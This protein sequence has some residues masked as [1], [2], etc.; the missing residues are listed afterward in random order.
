MDGLHEDLNRIIKKPY[1]ENPESDDNT[2]NDPDAVRQLG[3]TFRR[4]HR[5]RND[6]V[7]MDLFNGFYKN[8]MVCPVCDKISVTFDPYSLHT[9]QLPIESTFQHKFFF[10]PLYGKPR[11]VDV[12]ID[13]NSTVRTLKEWIGKRVK[14]SADHLVIIEEYT[15]KLYQVLEDSQILSESNLQQN[16]NLHVVELDQVPTNWPPIG[17]K[18][19]RS[20][21]F[22]STSSSDPVPPM[23]SPVADR[24]AVPIFHRV[25]GTLGLKFDLHP[26]FVIITREEAKDDEKILRKTLKKVQAMTSRNLFDEENMRQN[27]T[28]REGS[29]TEVMYEEDGLSND[30]DPHARSVEGEDGL[31]DVSM[32]EVGDR[33]ERSAANNPPKEPK[34]NVL[35][36][37]FFIIPELR[38]LFEIRVATS[39]SGIMPVGLSAVSEHT[40]YPSLQSRV[41][42]RGSRQSHR[43]RPVASQSRRGSG[44]SED[45]LSREEPT[46]ETQETT[47]PASDEDSNLSKIPGQLN[48]AS[49]GRNSQA[50]PD[51]E[52]LIKLG[53]GFVLDWDPE[54]YQQ[55]FSGDGER[56][57]RTDKQVETLPDPDL[58]EKKARRA[59]RKKNGLSLEEC[60]EE[61]AKSEVLSEDNAWYCS[62]CKELRRAT[63]KLEIWT[64]PDILVVHLKRFSAQSRMRDKVDVLVDFPTEGLNLKGKVGLPEG[65]SLTYD[66]FAVDNH[67]G[68]LGGGHYTAYAQNFFDRQWYDYNGESPPFIHSRNITNTSW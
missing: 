4:N 53:E 54:G 8:T 25:D 59:S 10:S 46:S 21:S 62:R 58:A 45:E 64:V 29:D 35:D 56:G 27:G 63:K 44:S 68:G 41:D 57:S 55:L 38:R 28:S 23:S 19:P 34:S 13:K 31:V 12:D 22:W 15:S 39:S 67:Y 30:E 2:V 48:S 5:A 61:T 43:R 40:R 26:S 37:N 65:K 16:D 11:Y 52:Y 24:M 60:F 51:S 9:L 17:E 50:S 3:E 7:A 33:T 49:K 42:A 36:P 32:G 14:V 66:L 47:P 20:Y 1:I 6:S 18:K